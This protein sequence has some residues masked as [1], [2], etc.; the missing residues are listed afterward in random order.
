VLT[1][2]FF[3]VGQGDAALVRS[4]G[5]VA[6]LIDG[7]PDPLAVAT[8]LAALGVHRLDL[9]VATHPHADHLAGL[10][11]V[12][13]RVPVA[14]VVDPGC[15]GSSPF[16]RD[17]LATVRDLRA[18]FRHPR[19]GDMLTVGD[20]RLAVLGPAACAH[21][22]DSDPNNDSMVLRLTDGRDTV[23]FPGDAEAPEQQQILASEAPELSAP[24]LKVPHHGGDTSL[25]E[26]LAAV[27]A[28]V[29]VISVG[30][31]NRYGHPNPH[32]VSLLGADGMR[33]FR[34]DRSGDLTV[35]FAGEALEV[36]AGLG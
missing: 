11:A 33:V 12:L 14:L 26:F 4:P 28:R 15:A 25:P 5:G 31:P 13:R 21:G 8:K 10:P 24:L 2:V 17:F 23:L 32:L 7:G 34:T 22:T 1:V 3:D 29:A 30:Q 35:R 16:Y 36:S 27:H 19:P 18:P 20:L 6:I 9:M